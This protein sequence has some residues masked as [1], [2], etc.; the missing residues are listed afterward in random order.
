[1][2]F[3]EVETLRYW[4]ERDGPCE[5]LQ[6]LAALIEEKSEQFVTDEQK[7]NQLRDLAITAREVC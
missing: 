4:I 3:Q 6:H 7:F 2:N 5:V 1:M